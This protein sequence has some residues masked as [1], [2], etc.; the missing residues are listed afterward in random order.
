MRQ[1]ERPSNQPE[2]EAPRPLAVRLLWFAGLWT[3]S[4]AVVGVVAYA[5]RVWIA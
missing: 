4:V 3:A 5:I 1:V 2:H